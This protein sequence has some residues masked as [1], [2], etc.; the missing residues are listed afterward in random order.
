MHSTVL[1]VCV[2]ARKQLCSRII[3]DVNEKELQRLL[4]VTKEFESWSGIR[5]NLKKTVKIAV[6]GL[7]KRRSDLGSVS[8]KGRFCLS[9]SCRK[10][11][12]ADT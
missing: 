10:T 2:V 11:H 3:K 8:Y 9:Q 12:L 7:K 1:A 4:D 5:L 6:D